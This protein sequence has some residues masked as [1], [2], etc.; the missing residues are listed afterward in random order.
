MSDLGVGDGL[1]EIGGE[2]LPGTIH[3]HVRACRIHI[4]EEQRKPNPDNALI[5]TLCNSVRF[6]REHCNERLDRLRRYKP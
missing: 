4:A 3:D 5:E 1:P 6:A 2:M